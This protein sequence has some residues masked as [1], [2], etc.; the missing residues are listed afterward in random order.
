MPTPTKTAKKT[1]PQVAGAIPT[2]VEDPRIA[3][4]KLAIEPFTK[5]EADDGRSDEF[6]L[7]VRGVSITA[8]DVRRAVEAMK[9]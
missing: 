5:I 1:V 2:P 3:E 4:L 7:I 6:V 8:G 9:I